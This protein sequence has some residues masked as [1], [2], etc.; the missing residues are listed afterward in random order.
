[1]SQQ[2]RIDSESLR[3]KVNSLLPS[4]A[5]GSIGVDLTGSTTIIPIVDLTE[6]AEGSALRQDLQSSLSLTSATA[7]NVVNTTTTIINTT[8]YFRIFGCCNITTNAANGVRGDVNITD[9]FTSKVLVSYNSIVAIGT[10]AYTA[11]P[12][13]FIVKC[14]AGHSV[15]LLSSA[16]T[17]QLRGN[18]RQ[19]A[20]IS[21]NLINP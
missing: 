11:I 15:S 8:G 2:F 18:T 7:F 13:D 21:G 16:N 4:Q 1:M 6:T 12:F 17:V 14:E 3:D 20:D 9:G 19:L 10:I 5:R